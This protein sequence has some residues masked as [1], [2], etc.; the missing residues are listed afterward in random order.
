GGGIGGG[1]RGSYGGSDGGCWGVGACWRVG[2][3]PCIKAQDAQCVVGAPLIWIDLV[4][5]HDECRPRRYCY[6]ERAGRVGAA[7]RVAQVV[8]VQEV[9]IKAI[10]IS[11]R[12]NIA[13]GV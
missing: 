6:L 13:R 12:V 10:R 9:R 1:K 8:G 11:Y 3:A 7:A 4:H 2:G 5:H